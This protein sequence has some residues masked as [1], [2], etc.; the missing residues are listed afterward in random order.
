MANLRIY[1]T[2]D[3]SGSISPDDLILTDKY[4]GSDSYTTGFKKIS[5]IINYITVLPTANFTNINT[6]INNNTTAITTLDNSIEPRIETFTR[7]T[8]VTRDFRSIL[9]SGNG[10]WVYT[11]YIQFPINL[12]NVN[13]TNDDKHLFFITCRMTAYTVGNNSAAS[14]YRN[15]TK[16]YAITIDDNGHYIIRSSKSVYGNMSNSND[17]GVL[18]NSSF[19][20]ANFQ[21]KGRTKNFTNTTSVYF[22]TEF[23]ISF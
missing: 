11:A 22:K 18:L 12:T 17:L 6:S 1:Q 5:D 23:S 15:A 4:Q 8:A 21:V 13:I 20:G 14:S 10:N 3:L 16:I 2:L 19:H 7:T 9:S